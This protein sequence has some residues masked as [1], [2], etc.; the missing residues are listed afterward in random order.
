MLGRDKNYIY[1]EAS[2]AMSSE[3]LKKIYGVDIRVVKNI[4]D[5]REHYSCV[6]VD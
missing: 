3:N 4:I 1:G 6:M 5:E 2:E